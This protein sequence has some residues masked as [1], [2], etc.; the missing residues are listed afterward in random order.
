[1]NDQPEALP[2][3]APLN[4]Y[5][6]RCLNGWSYRVASAHDLATFVKFA[7]AD[8]GVGADKMFIPWHGICNI[9]YIGPFVPNS[10]PIQLVRP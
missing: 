9:E 3:P 1:M 5:E 4:N 10:G 8:G 2:A 6:V 7:Q